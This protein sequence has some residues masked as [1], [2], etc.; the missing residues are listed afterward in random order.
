MA[1]SGRGCRVPTSMVLVFEKASGDP[2]EGSKCA[3][4]R[5]SVIPSLARRPPAFSRRY[6]T[7]S[8]YAAIEICNLYVPAGGGAVAGRGRRVVNAEVYKFL[9]RSAEASPRER[10]R[11]EIRHE[12]YMNTFDECATVSFISGAGRRET[13]LSRPR[14]P[15]PPRRAAACCV[16]SRL[17]LRTICTIRMF[18]CRC[19]GCVWRA[20]PSG[21]V[22]II[23]TLILSL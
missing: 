5:E 4:A 10:R 15:C 12:F 1:P 22:T 9:S 2:A 16:T 6:F 11:H 20:D 18:K 8:N 13:C 19:C 21:S 14:R 7:F 23:Y 3:R 17:L